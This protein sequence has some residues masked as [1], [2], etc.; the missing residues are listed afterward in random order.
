MQK[1]PPP[2]GPTPAT[3]PRRSLGAS[4][5]PAA[6]KFCSGSASG[7]SS[8]SP[9]SL[10]GL[11][12]DLGENCG[13]NCRHPH[14]QAAP[15]S[16]KRSRESWSQAGR[17]AACSACVGW[18]GMMDGWSGASRRRGS[19][20]SRCPPAG[21]A[22]SAAARTTTNPQKAKFTSKVPPRVAAYLREGPRPR[23][24][25]WSPPAR[26]APPSSPRGRCTP[27]KWLRCRVGVRLSNKVD[28]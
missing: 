3:L 17:T 13:A 6:R 8:T 5:A 14:C 16:H 19:T 28:L 18:I 10:V 21:C 23:C 20:C 2:A 27:Q 9:P 1:P 12:V 15:R 25:K 24:S 7:A 11:L 22:V 26:G 4:W